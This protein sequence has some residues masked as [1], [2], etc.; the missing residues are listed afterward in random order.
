MSARLTSRKPLDAASLAPKWELSSYAANWKGVAYMLE[1]NLPPEIKPANPLDWR[2]LGDITAEAFSDD[3]VNRWVFGNEEAIRST[4][5]LLA[6]D[7]YLRHG[8]CHLVGDEAASM[9]CMHDASRELG[10]VGT[11]K[12]GWALL[13]KGSKGALGRAMK[14]GSVMDQH[15]P[16]EPH[17]YLFTIGTRKAARGKG[18]G[19][20]LMRAML[21]GADRDGLPCYLENSNP[22]NTGFYRSHGFERMRLFEVGE[23]SPP[24]EAMWRVPKNP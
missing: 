19:K 17:L 20:M 23:G 21:E 7:V 14:A 10:P 13:T 2:E 18:Y 6:R 16:K 8:L 4:F 5:R 24:L 15:H 12:L 3:P 11:L 22:D 1:L 9:W